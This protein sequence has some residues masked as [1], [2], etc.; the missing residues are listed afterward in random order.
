MKWIK[1]FNEDENLHTVGKV[2]GDFVQ[3]IGKFNES[4][5]AN[6]AAAAPELLESLTELSDWMRGTTWETHEILVRA[7]NVLRK[8]KESQI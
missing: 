7:Y 5:D 6:L 1:G 8:V 4:N 2:K 3:I